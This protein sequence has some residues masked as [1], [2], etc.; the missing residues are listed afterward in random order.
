MKGKLAAVLLIAIAA[1]AAG[2][3]AI[4]SGGSADGAATPAAKPKKP[5][6]F[7]QHDLFIEYNATDGD[8]GLQLNLDAENWK[9]FTLRDPRGRVLVNMT[10]RGRLSHPPHGL[11]E[12]FFEA[13]EPPFTQVPFRRF[14]RLFPEGT[15]RFSG[16]AG[17]G[18]RMTGSDRLSHLIPG[19]PHVISPTRGAQ[20]DPNG[21]RVSWDPVRSP[22]GVKIVSYQVTVKLGKREL[23]MYLPATATSVA[24]P[25]EFLEPGKPLEAEVLARESSG[26]QTITALPPFRTR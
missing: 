5:I 10:A 7:E 21:F 19:A 9:K 20:V 13:S 14:K 18:R 22:A 6:P 12:L 16:I 15:Y 3:L 23:S 17:N 26:N 1:L 2:V 11:S 25:G 8:A 24:I 4:A